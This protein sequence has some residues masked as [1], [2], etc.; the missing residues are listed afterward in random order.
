MS[1]IAFHIVSLDDEPDI[2]AM[3]KRYFEKNGLPVSTVETAADFWDL[4]AQRPVDIA[5][6]DIN[7]PGE[8]G[9]SIA[10]ELRK[11]GNCGIIF[12]TANNDD[13][14]KIVGLEVGAD[15]YVT[16][17]FNPRELLARVR[18][19]MR[20]LGEREEGEAATAGRE[21]VIGKCRLNLESRSL[22]D[23]D[24]GEVALTAMEYDL[25]DAFARHPNQVLSRDRLLDLAH[26]KEDKA[27]DRSIDTRIVRLRKKIEIDPAHPRAIRT[28]RGVG[29]RF[30]PGEG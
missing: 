6:L 30:C 27:F 15:D 17:P 18:S 3:I 21:V 19:L 24:G 7:M 11:R 4:V 8:D 28:V 14:D 16:K 10:R 22:F 12:L 26:G 1:A 9:V 20:R 23:A 5:L 25:L 2:G 29:Y 13:V